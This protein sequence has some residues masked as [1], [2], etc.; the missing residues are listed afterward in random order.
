M[1]A[2]AFLSNMPEAVGATVGLKKG[3]MSARQLMGLWLAIVAVSGASS[4]FGYVVLDDASPSLG[5][6]FQA[7]AA[8]A[9][10]TMLVD[11]MIPEA[12]EEG[13]RPVGLITVL[14]FALAVG[15]SQFE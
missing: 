4:A 15:L 10:L 8:G 14:G 13:G 7:F 11:S 6:F 5:A 9:I 12:Y 3:G 1:V 2:A